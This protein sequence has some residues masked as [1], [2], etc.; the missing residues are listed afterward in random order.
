MAANPEIAESPA[1]ML[2][3]LVRLV[4]GLRP[5]WQAPGVQAAISDAIRQNPLASQAQITAAAVNA[6]KDPNNRTPAVIALPGR[7][8]GDALPATGT[9]LAPYKPRSTHEQREPCGKRVCSC[10]HEL[11]CIDGWIEVH[12]A[13]KGSLATSRRC[14]NC[15]PA[16][17]A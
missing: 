15:S 1:T 14:P 12:P 2:N 17:A 7:H 8:W 11:P 16:S 5:D 9:P 10:T 13:R 6:A 3:T 4:C